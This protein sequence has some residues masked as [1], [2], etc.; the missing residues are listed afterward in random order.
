[1]VF[2]VMAEQT[3]TISKVE[4]ATVFNVRLL[5]EQDLERDQRHDWRLL[6]K[7]LFSGVLGYQFGDGS[8]VDVKQILD[9]ILLSNKRL[10]QGGSQ[11]F[12]GRVRLLEMTVTLSDGTKTTILLPLQKNQVYRTND[13]LRL[14]HFE[15]GVIIVRVL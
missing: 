7:S 6:S 4:S 15:T 3:M 12:I 8:A 13:Q 9:A 14:V 5:S 11:A 10:E 1:M 2:N